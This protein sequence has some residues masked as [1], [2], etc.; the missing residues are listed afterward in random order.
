MT[1]TAI[2]VLIF[3]GIILILVEFL[4]L[5]GTNIAGIIGLLLI[6]GGIYFSYKDLNTIVAHF[7]LGGTFLFMIAAITFAIRSNTWQKLS[8]NTSIDSKVENIKKDTVAVGDKGITITRLAPIGKAMVNEIA[9]EAKS[10]HK[11]LDPN[12]PIEVINIMGNQI[13]VKPAD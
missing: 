10:N 11:F 12:T 6:I 5:P 8:L 7:I 3:I 1:L 13:I 9:F 2:L 4:V